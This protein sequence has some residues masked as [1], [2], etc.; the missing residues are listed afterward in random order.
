MMHNIRRTFQRLAVPLV[1]IAAMAM[2]GCYTNDPGGYTT[3]G[4]GGSMARFAIVGDHLYT[5]SQTSLTHYDI[6]SPFSPVKGASIGVGFNIETISPFS[7]YLFL[8]SSFEMYIYDI[9]NP[10]APLLRGETNHWRSRDPVVA[11]SN[12]AYVT[13]QDRGSLEVYDIQ[14]LS[15]LRLVTRYGLPSPLGVA[16]D[17]NVLFVATGEKG[18]KMA[19]RN[20]KTGELPSGFSTIDESHAYDLIP[21]HGLLISTGNSGITQFDY[22]NLDSV[23]RV[24]KISV[25]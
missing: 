2:A 1:A 19:K 20:P 21:L 4:A 11:D 12:F 17:S 24:S 6:S 10:N 25:K 8:G 9:S 14:D 5:V 16:L 3:E 15:D 22:R 13:L 23:F 18:L 7:K